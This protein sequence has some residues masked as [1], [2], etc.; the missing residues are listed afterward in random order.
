MFPLESF[1]LYKRLVAPTVACDYC[2]I[3]RSPLL[4]HLLPYFRDQSYSKQ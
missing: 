2:T 3:T 4:L 1:I